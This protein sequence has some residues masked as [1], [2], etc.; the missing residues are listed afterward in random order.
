[1]VR[2]FAKYMSVYKLMQDGV[3]GGVWSKH[4]PLTLCHKMQATLKV[5]HVF[6]VN[7]VNN[8]KVY[9]QFFHRKHFI[10]VTKK[11]EGG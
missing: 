11:C 7:T 6:N 1:M 8:I 2:E 9:M 4:F 5:L 3:I 10:F